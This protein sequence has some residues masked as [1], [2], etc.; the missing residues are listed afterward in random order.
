[1]EQ[2]YYI[3][4]KFQ[5]CFVFIPKFSDVFFFSNVPNILVIKCVE[6]NLRKSQVTR[7]KNSEY[8]RGTPN[9]GFLLNA[10]KTLFGLSRVLLDLQK[11]ILS[12]AIKFISVRPCLGQLESFRNYQG[13]T[14]YFP[15]NFTAIHRF[16]E[17]EIFLIPP[18]PIAFWIPKILGFPF[19][20]KNSVIWG[21][22]CEKLNF[23]KSQGIYQISFES[24]SIKGTVIQ[25]FLAFLKVQKILGNFLLLRTEKSRWVP[26]GM[27][28]LS[29]NKAYLTVTQCKT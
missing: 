11:Y 15:E 10:L 26:P 20:A 12:G 21:M 17:S 22:K 24:C 28:L 19:S 23:R 9:D 8:L 27:Q 13:F 7:K 6:H 25:K 1:M 5:G 18:L 2:P 29:G 4:R 3:V 14:D 16:Y